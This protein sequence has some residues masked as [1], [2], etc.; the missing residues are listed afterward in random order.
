MIGWPPP[1][2]QR[3]YCQMFLAPRIEIVHTL[4]SRWLIGSPSVG[5]VG[6]VVVVVAM[7]VVAVVAVVV[8]DVVVAVA[9]AAKAA[10]AAVAAV[11]PF[12]R[13]GRWRSNRP[14][15]LDKSA[16]RSSVPCPLAAADYKRKAG[17][18]TASKAALLLEPQCL[19]VH[20]EENIVEH[21]TGWTGLPSLQIAVP[22]MVVAP[23]R[24][25]LGLGPVV[26]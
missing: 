1:I 15:W 23:P 6:A 2:G 16:L 13:Q 22:S 19:S 12:V 17:L 21:Q 10:A 25:W 18:S 24:T 7:V 14:Y 11:A 3:A 26:H 8:V 20:L 9:A 5:S 4:P